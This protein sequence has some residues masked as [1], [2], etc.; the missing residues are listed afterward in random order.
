M[1]LFTQDVEGLKEL[2]AHLDELTPDDGQIFWYEQSETRE[3]G[4]EVDADTYGD[5]FRRIEASPYERGFF[6]LGSP[7]SFRGETPEEVMDEGGIV[8]LGETIEDA[9]ETLERWG[10]ACGFID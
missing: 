8:F 9:I 5:M 2:H 3:W 4:N 7:Y 6:L 1:G 10:K